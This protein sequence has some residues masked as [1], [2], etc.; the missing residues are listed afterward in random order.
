[1]HRSLAIQ[2]EPAAVRIA[3]ADA[4]QPLRISDVAV[5]ELQEGAELSS[6]SDSIARYVARHGLARADAA[7]VIERGQIEFR[8]IELPAAPD[9]ELPDLVRYQAK[10]HFSSSAEGQIFDFIR[11]VNGKETAPVHV[12]AGA[13]STADLKK[14]Q[15]AF[16]PAKIRVRHVLPRPF[17]LVN[18]LRHELIAPK[19]VLLV[20]RIGNEFDLTVAYR[21]RIILTRTVRIPGGR[22][23]IAAPL[24]SEIRR[25]MGAAANQPNG[26]LIQKILVI[27]GAS[28]HRQFAEM[29]EQQLSLPI[30]VRAIQDFV[31]LSATAAQEV[32]EDDGAFA[33]LFGSLGLPN[34]PTEHLIDFAQPHRRP[35]P[36]RDP[37][38]KYRIAGIAAAVGVAL[39]S[40]VAF[41]FW[42]RAGEVRRLENQLRSLSANSQERDLLIGKIETIDRWKRGDL[43]WLDELYEISQRFPLPDDAMVTH[44]S[45][46]VN[47]ST[48]EAAITINGMIT[49]PSVENNIVDEL[50]ERPYFVS[51]GKSSPV[52]ESKRFSRS[53]DLRL[54]V[55]LALRNVD[56]LLQPKRPVSP[57]KPQES[58]SDAQPN[59]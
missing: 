6:L 8:M 46:S 13:F 15:S 47:A 37:R 19:Y 23:E 55:P 36:V 18:L 52:S 2:C 41:L 51:Q 5:F 25:T 31:T 3:I 20:N 50:R 7:V 1:M 33:P 28:L 17:A 44:L 56:Q 59:N 42:M 38:Q 30:E 24:L 34:E 35:E 11:L 27:G 16:E 14:L 54:A 9:E 49:Q 29:V 26:G 4:G 57:E 32:G 45:T 40:F 39:L 53:F 58:P 22:G 43:N 10:S 21:S 12:L 48:E